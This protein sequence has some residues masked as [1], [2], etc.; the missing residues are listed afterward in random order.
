M[1]GQIYL[2]VNELAELIAKRYNISSQV[3]IDDVY[4]ESPPHFRG[5]ITLGVGCTMNIGCSYSIK[6]SKP[7][8][9]AE[10]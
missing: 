6:E 9:E 5:N 4:I 2:T 10:R 7:K 3:Y 1:N 8:K